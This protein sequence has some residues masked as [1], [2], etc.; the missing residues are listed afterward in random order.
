MKLI[1]EEDLKEQES[2]I[3]YQIS[4]NSTEQIVSA[5]LFQKK[6]KQN[7][8]INE[9][10]SKGRMMREIELFIEKNM[11]EMHKE[12]FSIR[13]NYEEEI[14]QLTG[15]G[16]VYV[17]IIESLKEEMSGEIDNMKAQYEDLRLRGVESITASYKQKSTKRK[18]LSVSS[19]SGF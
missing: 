15:L 11:E 14:S 6:D 4:R 1:I 3:S 9:S 8:E 12:I 2:A 18:R 17:T 7:L 10:T 5:Q 19:K 16:D 13:E